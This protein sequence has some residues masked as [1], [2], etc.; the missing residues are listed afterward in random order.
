MD[1][2][3]VIRSSRSPEG[4]VITEQ[5]HDQSGVLVGSLRQLIELGDGLIEGILGQLA[6]SLLVLQDLEE[7]HRIVKSKTQM[8]RMGGCKRFLGSLVGLLVK[9]SGIFV[10]VVVDSSLGSVTVVITSHLQ[11]KHDRFVGGTA[12]LTVR[13]E[14]LLQKVEDTN[15]DI[16][17]L[18]LDLGLVGGNHLIEG[19][20]GANTVVSGAVDVSPRG[21]TGTDDIYGHEQDGGRKGKTI[22]IN[23]TTIPQREII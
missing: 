17:Q 7:A 12:L 5:L 6:G 10:V 21:T 13:D 20:A 4:Q 1:L 11:V 9:M 19:V 2:I 8:D 3:L 15:T 16:I 18:L 23:T 22:I 14:L